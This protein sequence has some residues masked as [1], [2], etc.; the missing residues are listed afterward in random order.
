[1]LDSVL[2]DVPI[3]ALILCILVHCSIYNE[4]GACSM[5]VPW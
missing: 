5:H 2:E 1:M 3:Y 4:Y